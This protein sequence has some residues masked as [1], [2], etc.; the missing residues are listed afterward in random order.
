M[1][2][3]Y[4]S[5]VEPDDLTEFAREI[6]PNEELQFLNEFPRFDSDDNTID[7]GAI[8]K[9]NRTARFRSFDG[10]VHVSE[11]DSSQSSRVNLAPLSTSLSTGELERLQLE[12]AR[13]GGT[14]YS[15]LATAAYN[16]AQQLT[17]EVQ[18]RLEQAWGDT[19]ADGK[20]TIA[21]TK[22]EAD[23]GVPAPH[24]VSAATA[25]TNNASATIL[26]NIQTW[27]DVYRA[28]NG[29]SAGRLKMSQS[30]I[31][32]VLRNAEVISAI[33][34][35]AAGRTRARLEDVNELLADEGLPII[36]KA[37]DTSVDID[38]TDTRVLAETKVLMLPRD[39]S[40]LGYTA[41]GVTATA[42]ELMDSNF[43]DM[44]F[45]EA[46]GIVGVIVK[47]GVPF[48]QFVYVDCVGMP[49]LTNARRLLVA[50]V[51]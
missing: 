21:E 26:T 17:R 37:Y 3:A 5:Y 7:F 49:V 50:T 16:D 38:G 30:S 32:N 13:N 41:Y 45:E 8:I 39:L 43:S 44:A 29:F 9:T 14:N 31:R 51:G 20:L 28:T 46:A 22:M 47:E 15:R 18:N 42:L 36:E 12:F 48:R 10:R 33:H 4:D 19:L 6:P 2:I 35:S 1:A 34:G 27:N 23:Y 40:K 24:L 11:R 25:W